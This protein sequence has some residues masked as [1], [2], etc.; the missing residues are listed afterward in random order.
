MRRFFCIVGALLF[1]VAAGSAPAA[2]KTC[3][4]PVIVQFRTAVQTSPEAREKR[5]RAS[6]VDKWR[7]KARA[8]YGIA[9]RFWSRSND[10]AV[11]CSQAPKSTSCQATATPCRLI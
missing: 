11:T 3:K 9:Y 7:D 4:E 8:Q 1:A 6:V 10:R 2:A 5:A